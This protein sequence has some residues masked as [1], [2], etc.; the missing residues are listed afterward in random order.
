[1]SEIQTPENLMRISTKN[2]PKF[3][4]KFSNYEQNP[5]QLIKV[6]EKQNFEITQQGAEFLKKI[7]GNI[8]IVSI[9]GPSRTG[10]SF[11]L[12]FLANDSGTGFEVGNRVSS[13]TQ[14]V[15]I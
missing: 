2:K 10:K 12:N 13:C 15:W 9:G 6:S 11:I 3:K 5:I 8:G 4:D 14:G 7:E 1:M